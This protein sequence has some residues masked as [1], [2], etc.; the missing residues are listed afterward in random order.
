MSRPRSQKKLFFSMTL[1]FLEHYLPEQALK[2]RNTVETYRDALTV[3]RRYVT[4]ALHLSIR[5]FGFEDCTHDLLLSYIEFLNKKGNAETTCNNRL[6]A[7]RAYLWYVADGD[8][9]LQ[10]VALT[11]SHV[12]FLRV[13]KLTREMISE[14]DLKALLSAPPD[15]KNGQRDQMILILLYDSAIRVSELLSLDVSSVN[16][17]ADIPYLRI[18]GKGD[19]ERVVAITE[20]TA[21]H[22]KKYLKAYHPKKDP[23]LP[24]IYTI[25]KGRKDRMS[26]GNVERIIKKYASKI[27]PEHPHFPERCYPHM[28]R[29]TRATNLY[30]DGI[31]LELISRILGHSSTE[32]TR[33][34]AVP[35]MEMMRKAMESGNMS[36]DEKPLWP[37]DEAEMARICGLR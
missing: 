8:I 14:D 22:I 2:S 34:Y 36:T 15:T 1:E 4:D 32:T 13:P 33:I 24:L 5:S 19:K 6:A 18:Y 29:R 12:P 9:S 7:I 26:V 21:S 10:S 11:A 27:R 3:F 16:L 30:Q 35:S 31:E 17:Y 20:S 37:D 28:V 25:I 23:D